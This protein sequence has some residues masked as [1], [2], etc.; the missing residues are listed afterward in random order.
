M[1][2]SVQQKISA[3]LALLVIVSLS[4]IGFAYNA[5]ENIHA[6][7]ERSAHLFLEVQT[8]NRLHLAVERNISPSELMLSSNSRADQRNFNRGLKEIDGLINELASGL[9]LFDKEERILEAI[10]DT[11]DRI[12]AEADK[13]FFAR[14]PVDRQVKVAAARSLEDDLTRIGDRLDEWR[15]LDEREVK[16]DLFRSQTVHGIELEL[17]LGSLVVLL[18]GGA[19]SYHVIQRVSKPI[20]ELHKGVER[21][22]RGDLMHPVDIRTGDEIQDLAEA[23]NDL[24]SNLRQEEEMASDIQRRLLP[25]DK[26]SAP[27]VRIYTRQTQAKLVGGDWFDYYQFGDEVRLLIADASGKGMPGALLATVGMSAIRSEPK[28]SSTIENILRKTNRT[29]TN[30]FGI[31]DFITLLS[32]QLS[33]KSGRFVYINCGHEPP[34]YFN[35]KDARW[36]VLSSPANLPLGI[37]A[38]LF[39]PTPQLMMLNPGDKFIL[40]TDGLHDV[41]DEERRFLTM[42][43]IVDWLNERSEL[44]IEEITDALI[45]KAVDFNDGPLADD[46]TLLGIE[47]TAESST[48]TPL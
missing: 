1:R 5:L 6:L 29:V 38:E 28:Y 2:M 18:I 37:S 19:L 14:P 12:G 9:T 40:Y 30:R 42:E 11:K 3:V 31:T 20:L 47:L 45:E 23:F 41:R 22:S 36:T 35:A 48:G 15:R 26:L 24:V 44:G 7:A 16:T 43:A 13:T 33:L 27:G 32:A 25:Q 4:I 34:L 17:F 21:F 10:R 8:V 39:D 46:I